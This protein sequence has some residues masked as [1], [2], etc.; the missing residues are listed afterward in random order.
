MTVLVTHD[1]KRS[2]ETVRIFGPDAMPT[3]CTCGMSEANVTATL[4][5]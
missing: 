3:Y 5:D 4:V 2:S 1:P